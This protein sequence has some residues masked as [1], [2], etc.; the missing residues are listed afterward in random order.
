M[1]VYPASEPF[2]PFHL[3]TNASKPVEIGKLTPVPV[4]GDVGN[5]IY[6]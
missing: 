5:T 3:M 6:Y 1:L 4:G 2:D